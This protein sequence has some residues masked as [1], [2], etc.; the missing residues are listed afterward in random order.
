MLRMNR[1][2]ALGA[3]LSS[4][5]SNQT[6]MGSYFVTLILFLAINESATLF[7]F[8]IAN[9]SGVPEKFPPFVLA[10]IV[11]NLFAFPTSIT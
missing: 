4:P 8:L 6:L 11:M 7:G 10:T 5:S 3:D 9:Q 2:T 1:K